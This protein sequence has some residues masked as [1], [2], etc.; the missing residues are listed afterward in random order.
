M[1]KVWVSLGWINSS[2]FL[3]PPTMNLGGLDHIRGKGIHKH[4]II[5]SD[6]LYTCHS[7]HW[8]DWTWCLS[9]LFRADVEAWHIINKVLILPQISSFPCNQLLTSFVWSL[10]LGNIYIPVRKQSFNRIIGYLL[11]CEQCRLALLLLLSDNVKCLTI[12]MKGLHQLKSSLSCCD[13]FSKC[14][15][16][17]I[18]WWP[19]AHCCPRWW[20]KWLVVGLWIV[21]STIVVIVGY[22]AEIVIEFLVVVRLSASCGAGSKKRRRR[23]AAYSCHDLKRRQVICT[24]KLTLWLKGMWINVEE[25]N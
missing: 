5:D 16:E 24:K 8:N 7:H 18:L 14:W 20:P 2:N 19:L 4:H 9:V 23:S 11:G 3:V 1:W 12:R 21:I 17:G 13:S 6:K 10:P 15:R 25:R 22:H